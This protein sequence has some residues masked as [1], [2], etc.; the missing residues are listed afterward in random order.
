MRDARGR[1]DV[2]R[3]RISGTGQSVDVFETHRSRLDDDA[4][5]GT[6]ARK[7]GRGVRERRLD[8]VDGF[9]ARAAST[10]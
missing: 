2:V 6:R 5:G 3:V 9:G 4:N 8:V 1:G 10:R 7:R